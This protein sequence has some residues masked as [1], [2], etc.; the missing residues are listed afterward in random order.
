MGYRIEYGPAIPTQYV[1]NTKPVRIQSMTAVCLLLFSL[2]V[3]L[4]FPAGTAQLRE[5]LLPG[6]L[7]V[8]QQAVDTLMDNIRNGESFENSVTTFCKY[9]IAHD[10]S[11]SG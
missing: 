6:E 4:F 3:R 8:T 9:I 2:T 1:H 10:E 7:T 11:L 5:Y